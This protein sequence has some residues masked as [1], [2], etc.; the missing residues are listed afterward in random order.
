MK[1]Y[2]TCVAVF[3]LVLMGCEKKG[4]AKGVYVILELEN[5]RDVNQY[6]VFNE[7]IHS[8]E[9]CS[10]AVGEHVADILAAAPDGVPK[11]SKIKSWRCSLIPPEKGG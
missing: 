8:L 11:D 10:A 6:T 2:L 7:S 4:E 1:A 3:C 5:A 9:Q